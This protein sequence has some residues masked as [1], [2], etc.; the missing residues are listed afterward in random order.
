[1]P[2][3][4]HRHLDDAESVGGLSDDTAELSGGGGRCVVHA[5]CPTDVHDRRTRGRSE[6]AFIIRCPVWLSRLQQGED[7]TAVV[8]ADHDG[9]VW[10][11]LMLTDEQTVAVMEERQVAHQRV[12]RSPRLSQREADSRGHATINACQPAAGDNGQRCA[13]Q[14]GGHGQVD[15]AGRVGGTHEQGCVRWKLSQDRSRDRKPARP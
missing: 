9:Q 6:D 13:S 2:R 8:V 1:M 5:M 4:V 11:R 10:L 7:A 14:E 15:V 3:A 12:G